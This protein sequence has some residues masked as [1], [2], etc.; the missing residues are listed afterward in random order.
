MSNSD[1]AALLQPIPPTKAPSSAFPPSV[2][3]R[4]IV[5][6]CLA[7][8]TIA[9]GCVGSWAASLRT[10]QVQSIKSAAV[11]EESGSLRLLLREIRAAPTGWVGPLGAEV[12]NLQLQAANLVNAQVEGDADCL[13]IGATSTPSDVILKLTPGGG[14]ANALQEAMKGNLPASVTIELSG[15]VRVSIASI[16]NVFQ[17]PV[18]FSW[19]VSLPVQSEHDESSISGVSHLMRALAGV[20]AGLDVTAS[21]RAAEAS[22]GIDAGEWT[23][24]PITVPSAAALPLPFSLER[25]DVSLRGAAFLFDLRRDG[26]MAAGAPVAAVLLPAVELSIRTSPQVTQE[27]DFSEP[28]VVNLHVTTAQTQL[29]VAAA[30]D[31]DAGIDSGSSVTAQSLGGVVQAVAGQLL[32]SAM[33]RTIQK[34]VAAGAVSSPDTSTMPS[35]GFDDHDALLSLGFTL[36]LSA[37]PLSPDVSTKN[38]VPAVQLSRAFADA[39]SSTPSQ[40]VDDRTVAT[41]L[42]AAAADAIFG[43]QPSALVQDGEGSQQAGRRGRPLAAV[44]I[45]FHIGGEDS[46]A[47]QSPRGASG[48][49]QPAR[50][51]AAASPLSINGTAFLPSGVSISITGPDLLV[52]GPRLSAQLNVTMEMS[53]P[54]AVLVSPLRKRLLDTVALSLQYALSLETR[55][56]RP[57]VPV[58]MTGSS[59]SS[60]AFSV[61]GCSLAGS[62]APTAAYVCDTAAM[63]AAGRIRS[64]SLVSRT[65]CGG[66]SLA[67]TG[68]G[69]GGVSLR[70]SLGGEGIASCIAHAAAEYGISQ[71]SPDERAGVDGDAWLLV[72]SLVSGTVAGFSSAVQAGLTA[73]G[74]TVHLILNGVGRI[75]LPLST[76]VRTWFL[77]AV[78]SASQLG[79]FVVASAGQTRPHWSFFAWD[80][81]LTVAGNGFDDY[82]ALAAAAMGTPTS[83]S[84]IAATARDYQAVGLSADFAQWLQQA[85]S[86]PEAA[87]S[88]KSMEYAALAGSDAGSTAKSRARLAAAAAQAIRDGGAAGVQ[89]LRLSGPCVSDGSTTFDADVWS[90]AVSSPITTPYGCGTFAVSWSWGRGASMP[91]DGSLPVSAIRAPEVDGARGFSASHSM[92][93]PRLH[94]VGAVT[95]N[96]AKYAPS[97]IWGGSVAW[98]SDS[99][100]RTSAPVLEIRQLV[101]RG[102][103]L[104]LPERWV[105]EQEGTSMSLSDYNGAW[106]ATPAVFAGGL[107]FPLSG[108]SYELPSQ[109][110]ALESGRFI[111]STPLQLNVRGRRDFV[112]RLAAAVGLDALAFLIDAVLDGT[113][114]KP[115]RDF[116]T[117][118]SAPLRWCGDLVDSISLP[119]PDLVSARSNVRWALRS[120]ATFVDDVVRE[121]SSAA[122][123]AAASIRAVFA[124]DGACF[125]DVGASVLN[126]QASV[127]DW[128]W[129]N[130][131]LASDAWQR[132]LSALGDWAV[133]FAAAIPK[134]V[135]Q[136]QVL[137][138]SSIDGADME[139]RVD[140]GLL[141]AMLHGWLQNN[142]GGLS[143][144]VSPSPSPS[145]LPTPS[146]SPSRTVSPSPSTSPSSSP[147]RFLSPSASPSITPSPT[148]SPTSFLSPS[149]SPSV[150][151]SPSISPTS[152]LSVT[153]SPSCSASTV[154]IEASPSPSASPSNSN[155]QSPFPSP[156]AS[157]SLTLLPS[158]S[159]SQLPSETPLVPGVSRSRTPAASTSGTASATSTLS[160]GALPSATPTS[161][162]SQTATG[163]QTLSPGSS[164]TGTPTMT[165]APSLPSGTP[166]STKSTGATVS[167]NMTATRTGTGTRTASRSASGSPA[168]GVS[169]SGTATA[170]ASYVPP[171]PARIDSTMRLSGVSFS[172]ITSSSGN[173][174]MSA[175]LQFLACVAAS[176]P[177]ANGVASLTSAVGSL[178]GQRQTLSLG[179]SAPSSACPRG[180]NATSTRRMLNDEAAPQRL[181]RQQRASVARML[182]M[183][184]DFVDLNVTIALTIPPSSAASLVVPAVDQR[185]QAAQAVAGQ[186]ALMGSNPGNTG[187]LQ[188]LVADSLAVALQQLQSTGA[189][190]AGAGLLP[191]TVSTTL[192]PVGNGAPAPS[193]GATTAATSDNTSVIIGGAAGG[194]V[195]FFVLL[196]ILLGIRS[197]RSAKRKRREALQ[198]YQSRSGRNLA[199]RGSPRTR[200]G[201]LAS[202]STSPAAGLSDSPSKRIRMPAGTSSRGLPTGEQAGDSFISNNPLRGG[203]A[204]GSLNGSPRATSS[205][206]ITR[207][208]SSRHGFGASEQGSPGSRAGF[209]PASA[210]SGP[211]GATAGLARRRVSI[212]RPGTPGSTR[213]PTASASGTPRT[214][215]TSGRSAPASASSPAQR[216]NALLAAYAT[217]RV[218]AARAASGSPL[219][220]SPSARRV[221]DPS[222]GGS[223]GGAAGMSDRSLVAAS[224]AA[225][226]MRQ[227]VA[228][229][230]GARAASAGTASMAASV[231]ASPVSTTTGSPATPGA[232]KKRLAA[233]LRSAQELEAASSP[234]RSPAPSVPGSPQAGKRG[235]P[236]MA[237]VMM[238]ALAASRA[239]HSGMRPP[240]AAADS[241][242]GA[243]QQSEWG[244]DAATDRYYDYASGYYYNSADGSWY[245]DYERPPPGFSTAAPQASETGY[246]GADAADSDAT[247]GAALRA[248]LARARA[249]PAS[250][251][252]GGSRSPRLRHAVRNVI[253]QSATQQRDAARLASGTPSGSASAAA[254][255][256]YGSE[257]GAGNGYDY[258]YGADAAARGA[259][260]GGGYSQASY[261][262]YDAA[263][264]AAAATHTSV[265]RGRS[266]R[267]ASTS[268]RSPSTSLRSPS[269]SLRSPSASLRSPSASR[270]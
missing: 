97:L 137:V 188:P 40:Y 247:A 207:A 168:A 160:S 221:D 250:P 223:P 49:N 218:R 219:S 142:D 265:A 177:L 63:T 187:A 244:Y 105:E 51:A 20:I 241:T 128:T 80:A 119:T 166:T 144:L 136:L 163:T 243:A 154:L 172:T 121:A 46:P 270:R 162:R 170:S 197:R 257:A 216:N 228:A 196:A 48:I 193:V 57:W 91:M 36:V 178:N 15:T 95:T 32:R 198:R 203:Q 21:R 17:A 159:G 66:L 26:S 212:S 232:A 261:G 19:V 85:Y 5:V 165:A 125:L 200:S 109:V 147:T 129:S 60:A 56:P 76:S 38:C 184:S 173:E 251:S 208:S 151:A 99:L 195:G 114:G 58:R 37:R 262:H 54:A 30:A 92:L 138:R 106:E 215:S 14:A 255:T 152:F 269:T 53:G 139:A 199:A 47:F 191:L 242:A 263:S 205:A 29:T 96:S 256:Y 169:P 246:A 10:A 23:T 88:A 235:A 124:K 186:L 192:P 115:V 126:S 8:S 120:V 233:L 226:K 2:R 209:E 3:W 145:A 179:L 68:V 1:A 33:K 185:N 174:I 113:A 204:A 74:G 69:V 72:P 260:D 34:L 9:I 61:A 222:A 127:S 25:F 141:L 108:G 234:S 171:P 107:Q 103:E 146:P 153:P 227:A 148:V 112:L 116:S 71:Q 28:A 42:A 7:A 35:D 164:P 16:R 230:K 140:A 130:C 4:R 44:P 194:A 81:T 101:L 213:F 78:S 264:A 239:G 62:G 111:P 84:A 110:G 117:L 83:H 143:V 214:A 67:V 79:E 118:V 41:C 190:A 211:L 157:P 245:F 133:G 134:P 86:D 55:I 249:G 87:V 93:P 102:A 50:R 175:L 155:S 31:H 39:A 104:L 150:S 52:T 220:V 266:M 18:S 131:A 240:A 252:A 13:Y 45:H 22:A 90:T 176:Q 167:A 268:L 135:S 229:R 161:T 65:E 236:K 43:Q 11:T 70:A 24:V 259:E 100:S 258:G 123:V 94:G 156:S 183:D 254:A 98:P 180:A 6:A 82:V 231:P 122:S 253:A 149:A 237:H 238:G 189:V 12:C 210:A 64:N 267:T 217:A 132:A 248:A 89:N 75:V 201:K 182:Q 202:S 77:P 27:A 181:R 59:S 206:A 158:I 73:P 224:L 225:S